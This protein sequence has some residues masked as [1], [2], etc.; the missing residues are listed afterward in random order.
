MAL[1]LMAAA[2]GCSWMPW[3]WGKKK[4]APTAAAKTRAANTNENHLLI[5]ATSSGKV[6]SVNTQGRF[7]AL[8]FRAGQLPAVGAQMVVYRGD[9]KIGEVKVSG[10]TLGDDLIAADIVLGLVQEG[11][12]VRAQ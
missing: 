4:S 2:S 8:Q 3:N 10:P 5:A 7:V 1:L 12:E 11:D 9:A 6:V